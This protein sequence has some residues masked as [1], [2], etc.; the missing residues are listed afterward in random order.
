MH[1]NHLYPLTQMSD[2]FSPVKA[3]Q[4]NNNAGDGGARPNKTYRQ[5]GKD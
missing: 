4:H 2:I 3:K 1:W 5:K